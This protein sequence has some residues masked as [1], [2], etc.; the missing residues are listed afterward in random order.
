MTSNRGEGVD[1]RASGPQSRWLTVADAAAYMGNVSRKTV[2]AAVAAG[3]R[4]VRLT[5]VEPH[6]DS[7]G[8][9]CQ[10]RMLCNTAWIDEFLEARSAGH[11]LRGRA[12][13]APNSLNSQGCAGCAPSEIATG[14][15]QP[16]E[17]APEGEGR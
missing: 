8:R 13:D 7:R 2:Y 15:Q 1:A 17:F 3:M 11:P 5:D 6:R 16:A 9:L 4:V 14:V 10:G 12:V